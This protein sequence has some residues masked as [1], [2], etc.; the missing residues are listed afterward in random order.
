M[1]SRQVQSKER[2][3]DEHDKHDEHEPAGYCRETK[4]FRQRPIGLRSP[5]AGS[6]SAAGVTGGNG[7]GRGAHESGVRSGERPGRSKDLALQYQANESGVR[8]LWNCVGEMSG[9]PRAD[10]GRTGPPT[11]DDN[12]LCLSRR[13]SGVD[14]PCQWIS[15][16]IGR[17]GDHPA[18][19]RVV[20]IL[21]TRGR[22]GVHQAAIR[23]DVLR[24]RQHNQKRGRGRLPEQIRP[25]CP[26]P[27]I[28][29]LSN[30]GC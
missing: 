9:C 30:M 23:G 22:S 13:T 17:G 25:V 4:P 10:P 11:E 29:S 19:P 16:W 21:P 24:F 15:Q 12:I 7:A 1:P 3:Q 6:G 26:G 18:R 5:E 28:G 14:V 2:L 20:D 27:E 8:G